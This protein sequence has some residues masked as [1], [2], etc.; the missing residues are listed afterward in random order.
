MEHILLYFC[1][2]TLLLGL[3]SHLSFFL[4]KQ[5]LT[6]AESLQLLF[7]PQLIWAEKSKGKHAIQSQTYGHE[8][9]YKFRFFE[10]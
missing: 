3:F 4:S 9:L 7:V 1:L 2:Y 8:I 10:F 6:R 5:K